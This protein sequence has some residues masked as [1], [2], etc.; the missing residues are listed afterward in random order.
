LSFALGRGEQSSSGALSEGHF[1]APALIDL[2]REKEVDMPVAGAVAAVL[3]GKL[4]VD[5]AIETLLTRPFK[6]E[7]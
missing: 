6:A 7:A 1:T 5:V 2:A 3:S 4:T